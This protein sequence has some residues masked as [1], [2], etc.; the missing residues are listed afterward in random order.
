MPHVDGLRGIAV[1]SVLLFHLDI[2]SI[3]GG[4]IGV[5]IFFVISGYLITGIISRQME[6]KRFSFKDFYARRIKR[7]FPALF[8]MLF[9]SSFGAI[10]FLGPVDYGHFFKSL[11]MASAQVA[12]FHFAQ[13]VDYFSAGHENAPLLHTWSL[14]VEEQFYLIWP[15]LL[16]LAYRIKTIGG[17]RLMLGAIFV[18]SL[19]TSEYLVRIDMM[20][21]FYMLHSRAWELALGGLIALGTFNALKDI[22][23]MKWVS[24]LGL[25]LI[26]FS[27]TSLGVV[28]F[29]GINAVLP[30]VGTA[31][32]LFSAHT[33]TSCITTR[34]LSLKPLVFTGLISYS[35]YLWHWPLISFYKGY[36]SDVLSIQ[37][38]ISIFVLSYIFAY[39]SYRLVEQPV[40][41]SKIGPWKT[42][43]L[44][45][46]T[47]ILFIVGSNIIKNESKASWRVS[48]N[49]DESIIRGHPL[50]KACL[51]E[52][53]AYNTEECIIGPNKSRYEVI[54]AGDSHA[55][56]YRAALTQWAQDKNLTIRLFMRSACP[57]WVLHDTPRIRNGK[58]DITCQTLAKDFHD[59]I[60]N[61]PHIKY[62]FIGNLMAKGN[63]NERISIERLASK[64]K[65]IIFLGQTPL[66]KS[67]P[68]Q[69]RIK[70]N[71]M[72][73][74]WF[75]R[76]SKCDDLTHTHSNEKIRKAQSTLR[77]ILEK[78]GIAYFDPLPFMPI[79]EDS[80]GRFM[81]K[82]RS[83]INVYGA[84][85]LKPHLEDFIQ[86]QSE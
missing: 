59:L 7:I 80:E 42:I 57:S 1:L 27:V 32:I 14:G 17:A 6:E 3:G 33:K 61:S 56:N 34:I 69:C 54:V 72:I 28:R 71:L 75:P 55:W 37:A 77:P 67:D 35:L 25:I 30:C 18:A 40:R 43:T 44:G 15:L 39:L 24:A 58:P 52:G 26:A 23:R 65:T 21:A 62:V 63:H 70:D 20:Q 13:E 74:N 29:P 2:A 48:Y 5:D 45:L 49:M 41:N 82:D 68:H 4:F 9:F 81:F 64:D 60:V 11:R 51:I 78:N 47:I 31:L 38:Q 36:F 85:H 50:N 16:L 73:S 53:G 79:P 83:H 8:A 46:L 19:I 22:L 76:H 10:L 12:N 84:M 86:T 66:Y